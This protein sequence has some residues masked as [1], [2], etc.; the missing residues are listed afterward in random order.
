[1]TFTTRQGT[2]L[3]L[4]LPYGK[5]KIEQ[6]LDWLSDA[7]QYRSIE[8]ALRINKIEYNT[9]TYEYLTIELDMPEWDQKQVDDL[10]KYYKNRFLNEW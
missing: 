9:D 8:P 1:M 3:S 2:Y 5:N 4:D 7:F 6:A 10:I